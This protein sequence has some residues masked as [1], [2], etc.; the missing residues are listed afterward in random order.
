MDTHLMAFSPVLETGMIDQIGTPVLSSNDGVVPLRALAIV[1]LSLVSPVCV[2]SEDIHATV[3]LG[4]GTEVKLIAGKNSI[5]IIGILVG[6]IGLFRTEHPHL[7]ASVI[8]V[9]SHATCCQ[10]TIAHKQEIIATD[11]LDVRRLARD[12][13]ATSN[14]FTEVGVYSD[15]VS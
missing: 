2:S 15:S 1:S 5:D 3:T 13:V 7:I 6:S 14:L 11:I 10:A 9:V 8:I 12:V 4:I